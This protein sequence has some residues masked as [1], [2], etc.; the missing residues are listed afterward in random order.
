MRYS[1]RGHKDELAFSLPLLSYSN[2]TQDD[3][4]EKPHIEM[5]VI[6]WRQREGEKG[7]RLSKHLC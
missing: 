5:E 2:F 1:P 3:Q 7:R 6:E 4:D